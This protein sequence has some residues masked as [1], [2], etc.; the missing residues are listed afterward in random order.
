MIYKNIYRCAIDIAHLSFG[1]IALLLDKLKNNAD[2]DILPMHMPGHKRN[3][4]LLGNELPYRL[5]ITEISGFDDLHEMRGVL[6]TLAEIAASLYGAVFAFPMVNG[7]TGGVLAAVRAA[8]GFEPG[9]SIVMSR[10]SH[11]SVFNAAELCSLSPVYI[12]PEQD[13]GVS[14]NYVESALK[15]TGDVRCVVLTSPSY[16]GAVSDIAAIAEITHAHGVP[17][18]IDA[19]HGAHFGFSKHFPQNAVRLGADIEIVSLH[20]TLPALTQT[21]LL[22]VGH[23]GLVTELELERQLRV[24]ETSSPSYVLLSSIDHCL[25]LLCD[26]GAMLFGEYAENLRVF[27]EKTRNLVNLKVNNKQN[28]PGYDIGKIVIYT[29]KTNI[30]GI[31]LQEMLRERYKIELEMAMPDFALAMTSICDTRDSLTRLADALMR[32]D[33]EL[34]TE[35]R[36]VGEMYSL[37]KCALPPCETHRKNVEPVLLGEARGRMV[38]EYIWAYPPGVPLLVPGEVVDDGVICYMKWLQ[39]E[40]IT[41][42]SDYGKLPQIMCA[43]G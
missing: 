41:L 21:S 23:G 4:G 22:L 36:K 14:P 20:K 29:K 15:S 33:A 26:D 13:G 18:I 40:G 42:R 32:I 34:W 43:A 5:D 39:N 11:K 2:S 3:V 35:N 6:R 17:L 9:G 24:F 8:A 12:M 16:E 19:A 1:G 28:I 38:V 31:K 10:V 30:T 27:Y 25:K 7:S 37:P